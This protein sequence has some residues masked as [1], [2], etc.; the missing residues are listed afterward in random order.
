MKSTELLFKRLRNSFAS[1]LVHTF[2]PLWLRSLHLTRRFSTTTQHTIYETIR[3][4]ALE[5]TEYQVW[6]ELLAILH[7]R[8]RIENVCLLSWQNV[9]KCF[10]RDGNS[11][12]P[13]PDIVITVELCQ[14]NIWLSVMFLLVLPSICRT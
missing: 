10:R 14:L 13:A 9:V 3:A 8:D 5:R 7:I 12:M 2:H 6:L 11:S 4:W 1:S